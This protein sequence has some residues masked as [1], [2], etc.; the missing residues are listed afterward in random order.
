MMSIVELNKYFKAYQQ[1]D[2]LSIKLYFRSK[3]KSLSETCTSASCISKRFSP[4]M[5][6]ES[7]VKNSSFPGISGL[8]TAPPVLPSVI[9]PEFPRT[10]DFKLPGNVPSDKVNTFLAMYRVHSHQI[11]SAILRYDYLQSVLIKSN[12]HYKICS[13]SF[14]DLRT[15]MQQFWSS[16]PS[17]LASL[18][19]SSSVISAVVACDNIVYKGAVSNLV[20]S[21]TQ[22]SP[23]TT[24]MLVVRFT[25][26]FP[27]IVR[28]CLNPHADMLRDLKYKRERFK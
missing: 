11:Y 2:F 5:T 21:L 23:D 19:F 4:Y 10:K 14:T 8:N 18:L 24:R 6:P 1:I 3:V 15:C 13:F 28:D 9:F 20:P 22:P 12:I 7:P 26:E 16:V 17:Q 25:E 27:N